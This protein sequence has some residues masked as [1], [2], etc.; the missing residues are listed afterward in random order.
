[1]SGRRVM[2]QAEGAAWRVQMDAAWAVLAHLELPAREQN[3][4]DV[5]NLIK[6]VQRARSAAH[7][8]EDRRTPGVK[9][10]RTATTG[11]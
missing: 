8:I 6:G 3:D 1:V 4:H 2:E 10:G 7:A 9:P 5:L 11:T